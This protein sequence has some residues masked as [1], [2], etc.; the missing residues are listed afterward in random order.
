M[1]RLLL[2]VG[3][4]CA[5]PL[6]PQSPSASLQVLVTDSA[7]APLAN[8][9]VQVT[10]SDPLR[11]VAT[12]TGPDGRARFSTLP[13]GDARL[14]VSRLGFATREQPITLSAGRALEVTIRLDAEAQQ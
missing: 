12:R 13:V 4:V 14:R 7:A 10:P 9:I 2:A 1:N 11:S 8:A 5:L 6:R 3:L